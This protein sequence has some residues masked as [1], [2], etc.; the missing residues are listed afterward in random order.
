MSQPTPD[1]LQ[2]A[3]DSAAAAHPLATT[4]DS[5]QSD[6]IYNILKRLP[7][8]S[9]YHRLLE[10]HP[11]LVSVLGDVSNGEYTLFLPVDEAW[12]KVPELADDIAESGEE[13]VLSMHISPHFLSEDYLRGMTN[14]PS[15]Y[16]PDT[17]NGPQ[18]IAAGPGEDGWT[19]GNSGKSTR[20]PIRAKNGI[21][22]CIDQVISPP[23]PLLQVLRK[24]G[25][26]FTLL[27]CIQV[28]R[29]DEE[30]AAQ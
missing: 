24:T 11:A 29:F 20:A 18:V 12:N 15:I 21:I 2:A 13:S 10:Q 1:E 6:T 19:Y 23:A 25:N 14:I 9:T 27:K 17:S 7:E 22:Y 3:F 5:Q 4:D 16:Q 30:L 8:A 28:A 26:F